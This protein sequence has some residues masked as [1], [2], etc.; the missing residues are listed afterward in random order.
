[1]RV[2][3]VVL[4]KKR[5]KQ[6]REIGKI[7]ERGSL[8]IMTLTQT[9]MCRK[10]QAVRQP[11][12]RRRIATREYQSDSTSNSCSENSVRLNYLTGIGF[13]MGQI[14]WDLCGLLRLIRPSSMSFNN[15]FLFYSLYKVYQSWTTK[16]HLMY[17]EDWKI[18]SQCIFQNFPW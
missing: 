12:N 13:Q 18:L 4:M 10:F 3:G 5:S 11:T 2:T 8:K 9:E 16:S 7:G 1:M 6:R 14:L 15:N 17:R